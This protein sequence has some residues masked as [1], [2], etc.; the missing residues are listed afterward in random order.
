MPG[1]FREKECPR[2]GI[3]HRKRGPYCSAS[4]G[5]VREHSAETNE[6]R[7][8]AMLEYQ[9]TPEGVATLEKTRRINSGEQSDSVS[10]DEFAVGVPDIP[11]MDGYEGWDIS[12]KW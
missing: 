12:G 5:N 10:I 4:C 11:D 2:C 8:I 9:Q 1:I 7:R 6:N 3:K